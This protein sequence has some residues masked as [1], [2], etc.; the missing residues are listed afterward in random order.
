MLWNMTFID[1]NSSRSRYYAK[2]IETK[3]PAL[4]IAKIKTK[5]YPVI[6]HCYT[7]KRCSNTG[8]AL[9]PMPF[10]TI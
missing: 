10:K 9:A 7:S 6:E 2:V 5:Y 3:Y 8:M 1:T 4:H